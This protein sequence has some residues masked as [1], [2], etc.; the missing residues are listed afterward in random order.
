MD[1]TTLNVPDISCEHCE[2]AITEALTPVEGVQLVQVDIPTKLVT[3][4]YD[5]EKVSVDRFKEILAEEDYPVAN[6]S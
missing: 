4:T 1:K 5:A 2:H 6:A 3:V